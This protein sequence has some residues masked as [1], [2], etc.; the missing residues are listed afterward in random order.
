[1]NSY[2]YIYVYYVSFYSSSHKENN[3]IM[4]FLC[5]AYSMGPVALR[6]ILRFFFGMR[7]SAVHDP[8]IP[9]M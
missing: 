8:L 3:I 7:L 1:M 6:S 4:L 5:L 2:F 9:T